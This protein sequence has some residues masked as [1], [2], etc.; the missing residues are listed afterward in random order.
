MK[1]TVLVLVCTVLLLAGVL[2]SQA[3]SNA[4]N[5][6]WKLNLSKSSIPGPNFSITVSPMGDFGTDDGNNKYHFR[7]DGKEYLTHSNHSL[8]CAQTNSGTLVL[9]SKANG[10]TTMV[11]HW[12]LSTDQKTLTIESSRPHPAP[13]KSQ[14]TVY[15][16]TAGS[17]GFG[18]AWK[19]PK[20]LESRPQVMV[21]V[22]NE[23]SLRVAF[24]EV[25]QSTDLRL[26]GTDSSVQTPGSTMAIHPNGPAQFL[27]TVKSG[28]QIVR[29]ESL[30][31]S[32]DGRTVTEVYWRPEIPNEKAV[33][34]YERQ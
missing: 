14:K 22:L 23:R 10:V 2:S 33:L 31:L 4:W 18:G 5:G 34:V 19:N 32:A 8:S 12:K 17:T 3:T 27:M 25:H 29:Q 16:R 20:R 7:C 9:T 13:A 6:T 21:L 28:G 24:P 15:V 26:D 30:T 11:T 1:H